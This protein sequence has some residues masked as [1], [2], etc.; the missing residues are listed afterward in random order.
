MP[1]RMQLPDF[2]TD[3][4][5]Y[6]LFELIDIVNSKSNFPGPI[7]VIGILDGE[8]IVIGEFYDYKKAVRV[9]Q[10]AEFFYEEVAIK[11]T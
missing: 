7:L 2:Y 1:E 4:N 8:P 11:G 9:A 3:K 5:T 10:C 6:S